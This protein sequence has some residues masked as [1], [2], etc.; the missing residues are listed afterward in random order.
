M[1]RLYEITFTMLQN[2]LK[3]ALRSL[4]RNKV[5]SFI[6]IFGL[7]IG[8][9][10]TALILLWVQNENTFDQHHTKAK[11]IYRINTDLKISD[12]ETWHWAVTPLKFMDYF[13]KDVP[14]IQE[15]SRMNV[16]YGDFQIRI[17]KEL[18][19]EKECVFVDKNWFEL[20]D[21]QVVD[22]SLENFKK[23]KYSIVITESK[24]KNYF[25]SQNPIGKTIQHDSLNFQVATVVKDLPSYTGFRFEIF[26]QNDAR[27]LDAQTLA[28]DSEMGNFNYSTFIQVR[29]DINANKLSKKLSDLFRKIRGKEGESA[30][31]YIQPLAEIHFDNTVQNGSVLLGDKQIT[32]IFGIIALLILVIACINYVNLTTAQASKRAKEVSIKKI[33]GSSKSG[34]FY[35]FFVE[36]IITVLISLGL[37][38]VMINLALP[39]LE[40]TTQ[41]HFNIVENNQIWFILGFTTFISILLTGIY[42][43]LLLSKFQPLKA[44]K[45]ISQISAKNSYFRQGLVVFQFTFTIFLLICTGLIFKQLRFIQ[46]KNLGYEK[47]N[48]FRIEL[49]WD[50]PSKE[51]IYTALTDKLRNEN[52]ISEITAGNGNIIDDHS[53]SSG[54]LDWDGRKPDWNPSTGK[55]TVATNFQEFFKLK[56]ADGRWFN[57]DNKAD[58]QNV[59]LNET[60]IKT[61][62]IRKP[63]IGQRFE[64]NGAKGQIIGVVK[65]FHFRSPKEKITPLVLTTEADL[66]YVYVKTTQAK[67]AESL[68]KT[69][70]IWNELIKSKPFKYEFLDENYESLHRREQTQLQLSLT[71]SSIVLLIA[72]LGL[73]GLATFTA[74]A[75]VKEIGIRK[76]LGASV[77]QIVQLLSKDFVL[78][79]I[80]GIV[81]ASPIAYW[82]MNKWLQDFAYRINIEWWVFAL[83]GILSIAIA[84]LTVS[85]QAIKAAIANPVKSLRTE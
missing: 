13:K 59:I 67:T 38:I 55:L 45:G 21:Y 65:D 73:F 78:L 9:A 81:I 53:S 77:A 11:E 30:N 49:P 74:E 14:E 43:S 66:Y 46:S 22:G 18:F 79:V 23:D 27:L 82:A 62:K 76:V 51:S 37:A 63:F 69:Q 17:N 20:F 2:Y 50:L 52:S 56:M 32:Y 40:E 61:F 1:K 7:A 28:N 5:Y 48:I 57:K 70:T 58:E 54:N 72:C 3:I 84:L 47:E 44:I 15:A 33:I 6:N 16:P 29:K 31:L 83:A 60:A 64:F 24:A 12:V 85:Y 80:L 8:M 36:S 10:S 75:R 42:P 34:L 35:Q 25:G 26:M 68:A 41:T 71:F 4:L 39:L 19:L